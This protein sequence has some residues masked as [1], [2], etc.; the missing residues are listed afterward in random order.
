LEDKYAKKIDKLYLVCLH[1]D[2]QYKT[3]ERIEVPSLQN[4]LDALFELR[5]QQINEKR[6]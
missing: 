5:L 1:P 3:Y 2:N 4:E 6:A